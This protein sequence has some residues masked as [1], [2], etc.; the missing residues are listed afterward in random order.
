MQPRV[1]VILAPI[2][3]LD[4]DIVVLPGRRERDDGSRIVQ[5]AAPRWRLPDGPDRLLAEA[6]RSAL[7][8]AGRHR[9]RTMAVPAILARG[10]WP[11]ESVTRIAMDVFD[12]N[13]TDVV[14][15]WIAA[16]TPAMVE[17]WAEVLIGHPR[18]SGHGH[19]R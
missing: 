2:E 10:P 4:A 3:Q 17:R 5:I 1:Q 7:R 9:A 6:Y 11:L 8:A 13:Q 15:V 12:A 19:W 18:I 14:H 16:S